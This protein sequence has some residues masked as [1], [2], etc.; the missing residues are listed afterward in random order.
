MLS[1]RYETTSGE[2]S[3]EVVE[4]E[5]SALIVE[6]TATD[7]EVYNA[8]ACLSARSCKLC[9]AMSIIAMALVLATLIVVLVAGISGRVERSCNGI[10]LDDVFNSDFRYSTYSG[11][12]TSTGQLVHLSHNHGLLLFDPT[13]NHTS[14]VITLDELNNIAAT[15]GKV[16]D[17]KLC[18]KFTSTNQELLLTANREK[19]YRHSSLADYILYSNGEVFNVTRPSGLEGSK[20]QYADWSPT[21]LLIAMV[22]DYNIYLF[23]T[24]SPSSEPVTVTTDGSETGLYNGIPD[25]V[26]E[27]EVLSTDSALWWSHDGTGLLYASFNDTPVREYSFPQYGLPSNQYTH[28][29]SI[30]YPKPGT[31]NPTVTMYMVNISTINDGPP[32]LITIPMPSLDYYMIYAGWVEGGDFFVC[33]LNRDQNTSYCCT[34]VDSVCT[35]VFTETHSNG[36]VEL[37]QA[38]IGK[39]DSQGQT[40][41]ITVYPQTVGDDSYPHLA[42]AGPTGEMTFLT[43]AAP[44]EVTQIVGVAGD[45][46]LYVTT[47]KGPGTRHVHGYSLT[48]KSSMCLTC[49][50]EDWGILDSPNPSLPQS[51]DYFSVSCDDTLAHCLLTCLGPCIPFSLFVT[52]NSSTHAFQPIRFMERNVHVHDSVRDLCLPKMETFQVPSEE[53]GEWALNGKMLLPP[54]FNADKK[55]SVLVYVYGGPNSQTVDSRTMLS[56]LSRLYYVTQLNVILVSV[57]GRGTGHRGSNFK[58]SVYRDLGNYETV[59][60]LRGGRYLRGLPYVDGNHLAIMGASYGGYMAARVGSSGEGVFSTAISQAPVTDWRYY[61]SIYTERYMNQPQNNPVGYA[62]SSVL[63]RAAKLSDVHFLLIHGTGDDNVHFQHTAQLVEALTQADVQFRLQIYTDKTHSISGGNTQ[64]HLYELIS[65]FLRVSL[66]D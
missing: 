20:I 16:T 25:W 51:C 35:T 61:D 54:Q 2:E 12:W 23:D 5:R 65:D 18:P 1:E 50:Q 49:S 53:A 48:T 46:I 44:W 19:V 8:K 27:E 60:Q 28:I 38:P 15:H 31:P 4:E 43:P 14:T 40:Q 11:K 6:E 39:L 13:T 24:S 45:H 10:T 57:D 66:Y 64:R 7:G 3:G 59:D 32:S 30:P 42:Q 58:F 26:Y 55:Y 63:S 33:W 21:G 9:L 36:W 52:F 37:V 56:S 41:F 29:E 62:N 34:Y 22:I 47:E 17:F